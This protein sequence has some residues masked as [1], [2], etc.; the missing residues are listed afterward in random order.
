MFEIGKRRLGRDGPEVSAIGLGCMGMSEF[1]VGGSEQE[2]IA[3]IHHAL[4]R[5][6]TFLDTADMYGWGANEELV[7]R[8]IARPA[9][10]GVPGHQVRQR[11]RPERRV[12]RRARRP[13]ICP[14]GL[15]GEPEAARTSR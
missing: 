7:G 9:R 1:Y 15:R 4:D 11:A 8:A 6:V 2:S 5:G 14:L 13:G 3:T 12:P 10:R